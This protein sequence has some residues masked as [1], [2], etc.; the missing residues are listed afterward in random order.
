MNR[1]RA[2]QAQPPDTWYDEN[3]DR[4][5]PREPQGNWETGYREPFVFRNIQMSPPPFRN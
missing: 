1:S 4:V 5:G 2:T 3:R